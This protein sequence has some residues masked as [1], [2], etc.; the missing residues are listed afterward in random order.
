LSLRVARTKARDI[1]S[2]GQQKLLAAALILSQ[3]RLHAQHTARRA[4]LLLDDPAAE[5]DVD[6]LGKLL[7]HVRETPCQLIATAVSQGGLLGINLG[8]MFHVKQGEIASVV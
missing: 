1:V 3:V 8:S 6:N 4:V 2:R 5:L 7:G